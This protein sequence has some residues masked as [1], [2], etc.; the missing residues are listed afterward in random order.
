MDRSTS[1]WYARVESPPSGGHQLEQ[2]LEDLPGDRAGGTDDR[3]DRRQD[4]HLTG[5]AAVGG[6]PFLDLPVEV[7]RRLE[8]GVTAEDHVGPARSE[9]LALGG[10]SGLDHHR[11]ALRRTGHV[12]R[13]LDGEPLPPCGRS[14]APWRGGR[15]TT[16]P[17]CRGS[18]RRLPSCPRASPRPRGTRRRARSA[19]RGETAR[20]G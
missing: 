17:R 11:I 13:P 2:L 19:S 16:A 6:G 4:L 12:E 10:G 7:L 8:R 5:V 14:P 3:C 1:R 15:R 20:R 9:V 18:A